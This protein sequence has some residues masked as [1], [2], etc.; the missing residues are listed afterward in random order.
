MAIIDFHTHCFPDHLA[1]RAVKHVLDTSPEAKC[2]TD[3]TLG[4]LLGS[5]KTAGITRSVV[6]PV[7]TKSSQ[8]T[9]INRAAPELASDA[10]VPFGCLHPEAPNAEEEIAFLKGSG[11]RGVKLHPEFQDFYL[12]DP[13]VFPLYDALAQAGLMVVFHAGTDPGPFTND[14]SLPHRLLAVH[15]RFPGLT[16]V[17][18]HMGGHQVWD[19]VEEHLVGLPIWFETS[20]VPENFA[21]EAFVQ[22][23]RKHGVERVLF[24]TDTPWFNQMFDVRWTRE[25]GLT[26]TELKLVFERNALAL[27][28]G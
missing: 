20:T 6:L 2:W 13:A 11:I 8:V 16:I 4:G 17:A 25:S 24:G 3:G 12:D 5:M 1:A 26:D 21:K 18:A 22:M 19:Q 14:H 7:A 23:C 10:I 28:E 9:S 15:K 27:L